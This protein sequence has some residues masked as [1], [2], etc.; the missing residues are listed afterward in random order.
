M[1]L[2]F[3]SAELAEVFCGAEHDVREELEFNPAQWLAAEGHVE[4]DNG[5]AIKAGARSRHDGSEM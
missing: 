2:R 1:I 4:E 5:V 3:A